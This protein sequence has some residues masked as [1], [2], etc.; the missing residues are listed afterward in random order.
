MDYFVIDDIDFSKYV[1]SLI[2]NTEAVYNKQSNA[3]GDS[4]VDYVNKKRT[5]EAGIIPLDKDSMVNLQNAINAFN[6]S[7]TFLNPTTGELEQNVNCIIPSNGVEY[8]TI[9]NDKIQYN[10]FTLQ[11][12]EL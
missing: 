11:F 3:A 2:I 7:I 1:N 5:I 4:V 8:F 12:I 10:A 9:R 6:V